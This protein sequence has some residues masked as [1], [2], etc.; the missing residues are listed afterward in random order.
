VN[1]ES[2]VVTSLSCAAEMILAGSFM[3]IPAKY[4]YRK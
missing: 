4:C 2:T 3:V 1:R